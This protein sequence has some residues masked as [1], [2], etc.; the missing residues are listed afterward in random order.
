MRA[1][2][3][4][5]HSSDAPVVSSRGGGA[6]AHHHHHDGH[7]HKS[8]ENADSHDDQTVHSHSHHHHDDHRH[9]VSDHEVVNGRNLLA[10]NMLT[11]YTSPT[12]FSASLKS[13]ERLSTANDRLD[14]ESYTITPPGRDP[15]SVQ[16]FTSIA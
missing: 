5:V 11:A 12:D 15:P 8:E 3:T 1:H 2:E 16:E 6:H 13:S 4:I 9:F 7:H 14:I 10:K